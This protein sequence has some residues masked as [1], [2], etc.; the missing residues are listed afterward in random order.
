MSKF[1]VLTALGPDRPG[2]IDEISSFLSKRQINIEDSRMAVL[3]GEFA[4]ILLA[5]SDDD[6]IKSLEKD[7]GEIEK[8]TGLELFI[9]P[10]ISPKERTV[11][12]ST[13]HRLH[14]TSLDH[15][16]LVHDVTRLLHR[17]NI[18][19]ESMETHVK[20]API[21]G[22]PIFNM[23]CVVTVPVKNKLSNIKN[24]L[25]ELEHRLD[26]DIEFESMDNL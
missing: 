13:P 26:V 12:P 10:T 2:L 19:I 4:I 24:E 6:P 3:G 7:R 5:S 25:I 14:V 21:S 1:A 15:P 22:T 9:K 18:N 11:D 17:Y 23:F 20:N 16:G 8:T